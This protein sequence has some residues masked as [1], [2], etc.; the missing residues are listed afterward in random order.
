MGMY[1]IIGINLGMQFFMS[2]SMQFMWG[3]LSTLQILVHMPLLNISYPPNAE[4][5]CTAIIDLVNFKLIPTNTILAKLQW[6]QQS[7]SD[8]MNPNIQGLGITSSNIFVN[9]G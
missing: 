1:A 5:V 9:L 6:F 7:A 8:K 2:V 4:M 3:M